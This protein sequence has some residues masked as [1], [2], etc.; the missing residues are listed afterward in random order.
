MYPPHKV[1]YNAEKLIY[2]YQHT[3]NLFEHKCEEFDLLGQLC[4]A[5]LFLHLAPGLVETSKLCSF[6]KILD[7]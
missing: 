6:V 4:T 1:W 2:S 5:Q 7:P 3:L